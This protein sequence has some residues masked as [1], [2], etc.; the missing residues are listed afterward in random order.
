MVVIGIDPGVTTGVAVYLIEAEDKPAELRDTF[1]WAEA[2]LAWQ[3][4]QKMANTYREFGVKHVVFVI[5]QFDKR[6]GVVDPD[7][8]PRF[9]INDIER[10]LPIET[11]VYQTPSQAKNLVKPAKS[12]T[13][14]GLKRFGWYTVGMGHA[15]DASRHVVTFLVEKV[16]HT[17]TILKGWPRRGDS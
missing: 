11:R 16:R 5:E 10:Y 7:F 8:T 12:G 6:P 17:P 14:D 4:M 2:D 15:N 13:P 3:K 9:I 1:Q